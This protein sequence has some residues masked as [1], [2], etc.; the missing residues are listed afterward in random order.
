MEPR[1]ILD[2]PELVSLR[3]AINR[4]VARGKV[5]VVVSLREVRHLNYVGLT[6]LSEAAARLRDFDGDIYV[7]G[8]GPYLSMIFRS[9]GLDR[10]FRFFPTVREALSAIRMRT[11]RG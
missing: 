10:S 4:M 5:H 9:V 2:V 6:V 7:S 1:G 3:N 11:E 8:A